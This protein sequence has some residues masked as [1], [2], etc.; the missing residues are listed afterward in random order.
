[1]GIS[2]KIVRFWVFIVL[3]VS[4]I[5]SANL[6][7]SDGKVEITQISAI[8][9]REALCQVYRDEEIFLI[10]PP[11]NE[12]DACN[13]RLLVPLKRYPLIF[14][15]KK[16]E[17]NVTTI[18][19]IIPHYRDPKCHAFLSYCCYHRPPSWPCLLGWR[20]YWDN[21]W[22]RRQPSPLINLRKKNEETNEQE[23]SSHLA[24]YRKKII[25]HI[26]LV[27]HSQHNL[28]GQHRVLNKLGLEQAELTRKR[29][30]SLGLKFDK[31][32]HSSMARTTETTDIIS[33]HLLGPKAVCYKDGVCLE[34]AFQNYVH[35]ADC[36]QEEDSYKIFV[37]HAKLFAIL[38]AEH[39][40][41]LQTVGFEF[42]S[43]MTALPT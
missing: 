34:A 40:N 38:S 16:R 9:E 6:V 22:D 13:A 23:A 17:I 29:L 31:I 27:H 35:R 5:I 11:R 19:I 4:T 43:I 42:P 7:V 10:P 20:G 25:R 41:S 14:L 8:T 21:N 28:D 33:K 36:K 37:C 2:S 26:F 15:D 32:V 30:A 1:Y 3:F 24:C 18:T 12:L 39:C